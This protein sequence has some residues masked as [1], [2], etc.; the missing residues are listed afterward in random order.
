MRWAY[1]IDES[2]KTFISESN[3]YFLES[4]ITEVD[5]KTKEQEIAGA[6][7]VL[8][9][10]NTFGSFELTLKFYYDGIDNSDLI[11]FTEKIKGIIHTRNAK[12]VVHSEMPGRKY[13]FNSAKIE[14]EKI[15]N[16]D[17]TFSIVFN[18]FKGY[19][20]S[21]KETD[22]FSLSSGD[23]QFENGVLAEDNIKYKHNTTSFKIYNGSSDA[24]NPLLRHKFRLLI[25]ISAPKGFKIKNVTTGDIFEYKKAI[26]SNQRLTL[27]GV[28]PFINNKRV[29]IDTNWQWLT[30][31]KGFN[32]IEITGENIS[33]V[34]T[35]WIFPFIYR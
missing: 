35:Q 15:T 13:A 3:C 20:E 5:T 21:L 26:K 17:M 2:E 6:D 25:N 9:G 8:V 14:W 12:Y 18:C 34:S 7:G 19:S 28:H 4:E 1:I 16:S 27:N 33:N 23:W 32:E 10:A 22:Q 11:L 31:D 30:L 29:G 24:I